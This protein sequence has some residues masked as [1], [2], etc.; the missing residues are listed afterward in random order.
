MQRQIINTLSKRKI[1]EKICTSVEIWF[2]FFFLLT[3]HWHSK[4]LANFKKEEGR[5]DWS[6]TY[7][8]SISGCV[9][10]QL[11]GVP[12]INKG[13]TITT[14]NAKYKKIDE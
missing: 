7:T 8:Y 2:K 14:A 5:S 4:L 3:I 12:K 1:R 6:T 10:G 13:T 11:L 9:I